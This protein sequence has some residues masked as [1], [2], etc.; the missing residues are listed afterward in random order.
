MQTLAVEI[1]STFV[2]DAGALIL[3]A[4][5]IVA[6]PLLTPI[7]RLADACDVAGV[8]V[9]RRRHRAGRL[10]RAG[11]NPMASRPRRRCHWLLGSLADL[12]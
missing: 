11:A 1:A 3:G 9:H 5:R 12:T 6:R 4:V 10:E 8:L 2:D 7:E